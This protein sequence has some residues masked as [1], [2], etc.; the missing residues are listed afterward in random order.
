LESP[1]AN[2]AAAIGRRDFRRGVLLCSGWIIIQLLSV[3]KPSPHEV[4]VDPVASEREIAAAPSY[5]F[6]YELK[7]VSL[8]LTSRVKKKTSYAQFTLVFDLPDEASRRWMEVNRPQV[9][10][11]LLEVGHRFKLEDFQSP[12]GYDN[13]KKML[14][15][16]YRQSFKSYSPREIVFKDW[17]LN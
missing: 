5:T 12:K 7:D 16:A 4:K 14:K 17:I 6:T 15:A 9:M 10:D 3:Q 8:P 1:L 11:V 13:L 2:Q